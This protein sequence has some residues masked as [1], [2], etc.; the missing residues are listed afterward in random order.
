MVVLCEAPSLASNV[1]SVIRLSRGEAASTAL[2]R[3]RSDE[4]SRRKDVAG[5]KERDGEDWAH[6][7]VPGQ[8]WRTDAGVDSLNNKPGKCIID[9]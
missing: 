4:R 1:E 6:G 9:F 7:A 3:G 8:G 2:G 5:G